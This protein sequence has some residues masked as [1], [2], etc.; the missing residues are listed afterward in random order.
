MYIRK[1]YYRETKIA[2]SLACFLKINQ[3]DYLSANP[4]FKLIGRSQLHIALKRFFIALQIVRSLDDSFSNV[5]LT[6][7]RDVFLQTDPFG[8]VGEKLVSGIE[9]AAIR[10]CNYNSSWIRDVYGDEVLSSMLDKQMVC[11]GVTLG[12]VAEV[13]KY[14]IE[15]CNEMWKYLPQVKSDLGSDQAI[16]N[17]LIHHHRILTDLVDNQSGFIATLCLEDSSNILA[18]STNGAIMVS[19]KYPAIVHQYDRHPHLMDFFKNDLSRRFQ[20]GEV[21]KV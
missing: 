11:A 16:H 9:P 4:L 13:E 19:G 8:L 17:Y 5:L 15:M 10:E 1:R 12:S 2:Y 6:D 7:S 14:L 3:K 20:M 21:A 18:D